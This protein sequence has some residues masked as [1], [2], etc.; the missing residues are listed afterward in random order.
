M[1]SAIIIYLTVISMIIAG[2]GSGGGKSSSSGGATSGGGSVSGIWVGAYSSDLFGAKTATM[3]LSQTSQSVTGTYDSTSGESG[4][5][6]G[7]TVNL[8]SC[9]S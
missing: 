2:C 6:T 8:K 1:R 3:I 7:N 4:A 9:C 5:V